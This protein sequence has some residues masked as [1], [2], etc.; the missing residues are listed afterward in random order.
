MVSMHRMAELL[1]EVL[2][3]LALVAALPDHPTLLCAQNLPRAEV[4]CDL[5]WR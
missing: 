1:T 3:D 5:V 2:E 4:N